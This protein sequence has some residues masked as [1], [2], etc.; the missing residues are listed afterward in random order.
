MA[1]KMRMEKGEVNGSVVLWVFRL[2]QHYFLIFLFA[3]HPIFFH[4]IVSV[5]FELGD[6]GG[7]HVGL[8]DEFCLRIFDE[9]GFVHFCELGVCENVFV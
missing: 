5:V 2:R 8:Q 4:D 1:I 6:E 9:D 3:I 7:L